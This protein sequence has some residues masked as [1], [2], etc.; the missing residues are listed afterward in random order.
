[1][2]ALVIPNGIINHRGNTRRGSLEV[3]GITGVRQHLP[4]P[5]RAASPSSPVKKHMTY[6]AKAVAS[7]DATR[8]RVN[9]LEAMRRWRI[10]AS[11]NHVRRGSGTLKKPKQ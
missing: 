4:A 7:L 3:T 10:E 2:L 1:L 8:A 11:K 6:L 5:A 9:P